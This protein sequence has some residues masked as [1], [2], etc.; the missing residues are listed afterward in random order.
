MVHGEKNIK[1]KYK[2]GKRRHR[3]LKPC[4][5]L[6]NC[7]DRRFEITDAL[8]IC[9]SY[10]IIFLLPIPQKS[11]FL[12]LFEGDT[13]TGSS[14]AVIPTDFISATNVECV[15]IAASL[16]PE[17]GMNQRVSVKLAVEQW[18]RQHNPCSMNGLSAFHIVA[19]ELLLDECRQDYC[20]L[21]WIKGQLAMW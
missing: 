13:I 18:H 2:L 20:V 16:D 14:L 10:S 19:E 15:L 12:D 8:C 21:L 11:L 3:Q 5:L 9:G 6:H 7:I 4:L 17:A 1:R